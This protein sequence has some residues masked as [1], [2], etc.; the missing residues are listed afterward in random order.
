MPLEIKNIDT[1]QTRF[2]QS[3]KNLSKEDASNYPAVT[4]YQITN[5]PGTTAEPLTAAF[6]YDQFALR[7]W[8]E[9][10]GGG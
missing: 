6:I 1:F 3:F 10:S 7:V 4:S 9:S 5:Y 8:P 2:F